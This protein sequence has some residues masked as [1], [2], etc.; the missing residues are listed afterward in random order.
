MPISVV[1][2]RIDFSNR[3]FTTKTVVASPAAGSITTIASITLSQSLVVVT[4]IQLWGWC[5]LALPG[6][7]Y[8]LCL[9]IGSGSAASTVSAVQLCGLIL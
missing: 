8:V 6:A 2:D 7:T 9:T 5:G 3:W 4:G 1:A